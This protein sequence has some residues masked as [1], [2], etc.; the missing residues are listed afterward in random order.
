M[1]SNLNGVGDSSCSS[2]STSLL[3]L[4]KCRRSGVI[5]SKPT[6][7]LHQK[8]LGSIGWCYTPITP[9]EAWP[10][11]PSPAQENWLNKC[12]LDVSSLLRDCAARLRGQWPDQETGSHNDRL[13]Y[14]D[15]SHNLQ[16]FH[17]DWMVSR[18]I[19][20]AVCSQ[21]INRDLLQSVY[22]FELLIAVFLH[23]L[24]P[25]LNVQKLP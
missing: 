13:V 2:K 3:A 17:G 21:H 6:K 19:S 22:F 11:P 5:G 9:V 24:Y 12:W 4:S 1:R 16:P 14:C 20:A 10:F 23:I 15:S 7:S 25:L 8:A 18:V